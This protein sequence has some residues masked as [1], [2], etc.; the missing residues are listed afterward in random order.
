M[1]ITRA[2]LE[3]ASAVLKPL[4]RASLSLLGERAGLRLSGRLR[5]ELKSTVTVQTPAGTLKFRSLN[6]LLLFRAETL[7]TKEPETIEWINAFEE[8]SVF[9]DIGANVGVYSLYAALKANCIVLGFE[10]AAF[11]YNIL[12]RNIELNE[13]DETVTALCIAF[14]DSTRLDRFYM[15]STEEGSALH[16]F[17][18]ATDWP[19]TPL[20]A[21]FRQGMIGLSIDEFV[22]RYAP[23][24]PNYIK[25]DVDGIEDKII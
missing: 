5:D 3:V 6:H 22:E 4:V 9:W 24:V 20:P 21:H 17:G 2:G 10:P 1:T 25:I 11:N 8:G 23:P 13:M 19:G 18:A 12:N 14:G 7:L 15:S 16:S